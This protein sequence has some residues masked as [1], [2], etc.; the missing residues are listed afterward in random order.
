[1]PPRQAMLVTQARR[2]Y[3]G[4][5]CHFVG[6]HAQH[7]QFRGKLRRI[8]HGFATLFRLCSRWKD[9]WISLWAATRGK[10]RESAAKCA[11]LGL[12][13]R[14]IVFG[15]TVQPGLA[16][17]IEKVGIGEDR[18]LALADRTAG[19]ERRGFPATA[20]DLQ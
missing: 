7:T 16:A 17:D 4:F 15:R 13:R 18:R 12:E 20:S 19:R 9:L 11:K 8:G 1:M 6:F 2:G 10:A 14:Q 3:N 5:S